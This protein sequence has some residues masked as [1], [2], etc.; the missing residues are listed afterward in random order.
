MMERRFPGNYG[1][2]LL[3]LLGVLCGALCGSF[4]G[5]A[6]SVVKPAGELFLNL[7]FVIVV[8][9]VFFSIATSMCRM[10]SEKTVGIVICWSLVVFLCLSV[11]AG[12]LTWIACRTFN[13]LGQF[14][15]RI[16]PGRLEPTG[17]AA[18]GASAA[19]IAVSLFTVD[20]FPKLFSKGSL[21]PLIVFA[22]MVGVST[23]LCRDKGKPFAAF[24]ASGMEVSIRFVKI[25]MYAAPLCLGC[26][27]ADLVGNLGGQVIGGY[28]KALLLCLGVTAV[29][30]FGFSTLYAMAAGGPKAVGRFWKNIL[31]PSLM[32]VSTCSSAASIPS[33]IEATLSMGVRKEIAESVIP[34]GVNL[35]KD[36][37]VVSAVLKIVFATAFLGL[38]DYSG[39]E[40][41]GIA[42]VTSLAVGAIPVG[43]MTG[44]I[45]ICSILGIDPEFAATL[46]VISTI[47]DI[48]ATLLNTTGNIS[49]ALLVDRLCN[50]SRTQGEGGAGAGHCLQRQP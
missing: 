4:F 38:S 17:L 46:V 37:S 18:A 3:L 33:A 31:P 27:F 19:D 8:P 11:I 50:G 29:I 39:V 2:T 7:M 44:E 12:A 32:S 42:L 10:T 40:V 16:P 43:G 45:L 41:V 14:A 26:Y 36:G 6:A 13:P 21:L 24:L 15:T 48:P 9:L 5:P 22:A 49:S 25:L 34:F 30:Y 20:D 47:V 1:M 28:L 23:S 35:H